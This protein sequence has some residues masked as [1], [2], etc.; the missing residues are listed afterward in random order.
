VEIV[1]NGKVIFW[2]TCYDVSEFVTSREIYLSS[3][4]GFGLFPENRYMED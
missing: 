3:N 4:V 1:W 2:M